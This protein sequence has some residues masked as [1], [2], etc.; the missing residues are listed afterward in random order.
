MV[1]KFAVSKQEKVK[2]W[3]S[4]QLSTWVHKCYPKLVIAH[5]LAPTWGTLKSSYASRGWG[6]GWGS[7]V[8]LNNKNPP[9]IRFKQNSWNWQVTVMPATVWQILNMKGM[10]WPEILW[11][12]RNLLGKNSWNH[13]K[14]SYFWWVWAVWNLCGG[15]GRGCR[16][17][18]NLLASK[19]LIVPALVRGRFNFKWPPT[20][21]YHKYIVAIV[22][23]RRGRWGYWMN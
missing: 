16:G 21:S 9:K 5:K 3:N 12:C 2:P 19:W 10:Q 13:I 6:W 8:G 7:A 14:C 15:R 4:S 23:G 11:S 1:L 18:F 22:V 20:P 17:C